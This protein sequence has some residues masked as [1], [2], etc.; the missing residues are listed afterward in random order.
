MILYFSI[1]ILEINLSMTGINNI[2]LQLSYLRKMSFKN[3][4]VTW[5]YA[6]VTKPIFHDTKVISDP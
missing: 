5:K 3:A 4:S 2:Q 6:K 1:H